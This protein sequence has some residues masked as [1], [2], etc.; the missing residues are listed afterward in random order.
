MARQREKRIFQAEGRAELGL[1]LRERSPAGWRN[2]K[3]GQW[4]RRER[5]KEERRILRKSPGQARGHP[6]GMPSQQGYDQ[7]CIHR[8]LALCHEK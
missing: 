6:E 5:E 3:R 7:I 8:M 1:G 4:Q 2:S